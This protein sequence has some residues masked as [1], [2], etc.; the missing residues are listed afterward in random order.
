MGSSYL[1]NLA[2]VVWSEQFCRGAGLPNVIIRICSWLRTV[3]QMFARR[4][5]YRVDPAY[6]AILPQGS[7]HRC[8]N[9]THV[10][11]IRNQL[12]HPVQMTKRPKPTTM[13]SIVIHRSSDPGCWVCATDARRN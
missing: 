12:S 3:F 5:K 7:K 10:D 11:V 1:A 4:R 6:T 2:I 8:R 13:L 9:C